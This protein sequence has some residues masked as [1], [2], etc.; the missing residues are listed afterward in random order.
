MLENVVRAQNDLEKVEKPS[1]EE[2]AFWIRP[3]ILHLL[4]ISVQIDNGGVNVF[5]AKDLGML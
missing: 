3:K 5:C 4:I 2:Y 1:G